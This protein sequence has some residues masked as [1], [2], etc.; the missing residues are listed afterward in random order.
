MSERNS[1]RVGLLLP[2]VSED[3]GIGVFTK[4]LVDALGETEVR[5]TT[6]AANDCP[7]T[8]LIRSEH[9]ILPKATPRESCFHS[10]LLAKRSTVLRLLSDCDVIH[11]LSESYAPLA[12][13]VSSGR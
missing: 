9:C 8:K 12:W 6:V 4:R 11:C 2:R 3:D 13:C 7:E 5:L 1:I 10:K